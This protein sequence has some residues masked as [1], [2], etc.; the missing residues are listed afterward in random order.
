[1]TKQ[2]GNANQPFEYVGLA[3]NMMDDGIRNQP[4]VAIASAGITLAIAAKITT[5]SF[6]FMAYPGSSHGIGEL[7]ELFEGGLLDLAD[8][9][10]AH[11]Q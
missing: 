9:V 11:P 6:A 2:K 5:A 10:L 3:A 1:M 7:A 8:A 4:T